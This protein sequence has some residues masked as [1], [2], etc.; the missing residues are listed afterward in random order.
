MEDN[1]EK[2]EQGNATVLLSDNDNQ[3]SGQQVEYTYKTPTKRKILRLSLL[4][5]C[6]IGF[7]GFFVG[8]VITCLNGMG[9]SILNVFLAINAILWLSIFAA[10][11]IIIAFTWND[12]AVCDTKVVYYRQDKE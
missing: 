9:V 2:L 11:I 1:L 7:I 4:L 6:I 12:W 10:A 5:F 8:L 3:Y